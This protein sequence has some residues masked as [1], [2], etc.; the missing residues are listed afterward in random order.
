MK[1]MN[2]HRSHHNN[3]SVFR[4]FFFLSVFSMSSLIIYFTL[5][6]VYGFGATII[7]GNEIMGNKVVPHPISKLYRRSI[8]EKD[9]FEFMIIV[10]AWRRADSLKRLMDSLKKADYMDYQIKLQ[11][12]IDFK[13]TEEVEKYTEKF[14]WPFGEKTI[15]LR[16]KSFGL[17]RMVTKSWQA[18][19]DKEFVF[20]FEDDIEVNSKYFQFALEIM[21][22]KPE[23]IN[24]D[25]D[26]VGIALT[27]PK[28]DEVNLNH[29]IWT[30]ETNGNQL[31]LLQQP[32]S[33]GAL[34][35]PW[36]WRKFLSYYR[37]RRQRTN[38]VVDDIKVIPKS[39]VWDWKKSWKKYLMEMMV[40]EGYLM[41]YPSLPR[42]ESFSV[43]HQE[44]GEHFPSFKGIERKVPDY[45]V[46]PLASDQASSSLI[47]GIEYIDIS[48]LPMFSF[49]HFPVKSIDQLK[50]FGRLIQ[51]EQEQQ[52]QQLTK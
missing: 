3:D 35:F 5:G 43:H 45:F 15:L 16:T 14:E 49:Y 1:E 25:S 22:K 51:A 46:V 31:I 32:C 50:E 18:R 26:F 6:H 36:K 44:I 37:S 27:T 52:Q 23:I 11:F 38:K 42:Q 20:F 34:Y 10:F 12:H 24:K 8:E 19:N 17:E 39:C 2:L 41:I 28:Y 7:N 13:P 29:S 4:M 40:I 48:T 47:Q 21:K 9:D 30:P 33:W